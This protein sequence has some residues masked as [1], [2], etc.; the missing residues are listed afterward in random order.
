MKFTNKTSIQNR[1][2]HEKMIKL[3]RK[4]ACPKYFF[5]YH[6]YFEK[7]IVRHLDE[8]QLKKELIIFI[9]NL[10]IDQEGEKEMVKTAMSN[11]KWLE[12]DKNVRAWKQ[13]VRNEALVTN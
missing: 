8:Q 9:R 5:L 4:E 11:L 7:F 13:R 12:L 6:F 1:T 3:F 10:N 2:H